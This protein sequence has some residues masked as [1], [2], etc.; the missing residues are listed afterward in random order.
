MNT[1]GLENL[2]IINAKAVY[3]NLT[4]AELTEHALRRGEGTL[5]NT[6]AYGEHD[7]GEGPCGERYVGYPALHPPAGAHAYSA[8]NGDGR[9]EP[10]RVDDERHDWR[11][12]HMGIR[13]HGASSL[14]SLDKRADTTV[15][16]HIIAG[17][18]CPCACAR[19][20][21]SLSG[22]PLAPQSAS[23]LP[24]RADRAQ[25]PYQSHPYR[26]L[27]RAPCPLDQAQ[28]AG[29]SRLYRARSP[30]SHRA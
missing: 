25:R 6:G 11:V 20:A 4:P 3:R 10:P 19:R 26:S 2:G 18:C 21:A 23:Q 30:I 29:W 9:H 13:G 7:S 14:P 12:W 24:G 15:R 5:S 27:R 17:L 1:H 22:G 28:S 16:P 8:G